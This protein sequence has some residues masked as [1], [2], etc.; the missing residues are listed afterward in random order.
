MQDLKVQDH[1]RNVQDQVLK[2]QSR[3]Q[4]MSRD[5]TPPSVHHMIMI[6]M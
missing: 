1:D 5:S 4:E 3:N 6:V 2:N